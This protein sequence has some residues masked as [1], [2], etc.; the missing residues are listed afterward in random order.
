MRFKGPILTHGRARVV[1]FGLVLAFSLAASAPA[2]A[3]PLECNDAETSCNAYNAALWECQ[4]GAGAPIPPN[5][6][7]YCPYNVQWWYTGESCDYGLTYDC[8]LE[9]ENTCGPLFCP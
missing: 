8:E 9:L 6:Y 2:T 3:A 4:G 1:A 7:E 5:G